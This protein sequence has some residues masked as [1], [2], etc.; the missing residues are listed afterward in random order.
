[1]IR[2][3]CFSMLVLWSCYACNSSDKPHFPLPARAAGRFLVNTVRDTVLVTGRGARIHIPANAIRSEGNTVQLEVT[4]IYEVGEMLA[5]NIQTVSNGQLLSSG[6]MINIHPA[7]NNSAQL[8]KPLRVEVPTAFL[9]EGMMH[10][11]GI[12]DEAGNINW[13]NP[14]PLPRQPLQDQLDNGKTIMRQHCESCHTIEKKLT[15]PALMHVTARRDRQ[16]LYAFIGNSAAVIGSRD[17]EA[18]CLFNDYNKT[19]MTAFPALTDADLESICLYIDQVSKQKD[20][21]GYQ[22]MLAAKDSCRRYVTAQWAL[23]APQKQMSPDPTNTSGGYGDVYYN[24]V[25]A[26]FGWHNLD[27]LLRDMPGVE[28]VRLTVTVN[29]PHKNDVQLF[30]TIPAL[31][32]SVKGEPVDGIADRYCFGDDEAPL[33]PIGR[34]A[35]IVALGEKAG[36]TFFAKTGFRIQQSQQLS[37]SPEISSPAAFKEWSEKQQTIPVKNI[38]ASKN[39]DSLPAQSEVLRQVS[40][41][42]GCGP[43]LP[44]APAPAQR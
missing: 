31:R 15:G 4:E 2:Q 28:K 42:C 17:P 37:I 29:G 14:Q 36:I 9:Q 23:L 20:P 32:V 33:M 1:M 38:V 34:Q 26:A 11:A 22:H 18:N 5:A 41:D 16:W 27:M 7:D 35:W 21:E 44:A 10:Y 3:L 19:V 8:V 6:G 24:M 39:A 12:E 13:T 25:I 40:V 30:L 43:Q